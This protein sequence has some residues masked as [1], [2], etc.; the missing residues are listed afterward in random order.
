MPGTGADEE[1]CFEYELEVHEL[2]VEDG[3]VEQGAVILGIS[4][5]SVTRAARAFTLYNSWRHTTRSEF[6]DLALSRFI[7]AAARRHGSR[8]W[9]A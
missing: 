5:V 9:L 3:T 7:V 1:E 6:S 2:I 4:P 8:H